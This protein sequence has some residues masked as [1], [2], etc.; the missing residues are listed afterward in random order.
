MVQ[1]IQ[2]AETQI[3]GRNFDIWENNTGVYPFFEWG[4]A[5]HPHK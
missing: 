1:K 3:V 4:N 5:P 2:F